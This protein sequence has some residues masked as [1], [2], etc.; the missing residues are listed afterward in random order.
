L[1]KSFFGR[2]ITTVSQE[3][4]YQISKIVVGI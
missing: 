2:D 1:F 3:E 4:P